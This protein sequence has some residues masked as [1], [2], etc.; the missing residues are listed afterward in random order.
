V[1]TALGAA[2]IAGSRM[3]ALGRATEAFVAPNDTDANRALNR[4]VVIIVDRP[5]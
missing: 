5:T 1:Q 2:G 4:R 3:H